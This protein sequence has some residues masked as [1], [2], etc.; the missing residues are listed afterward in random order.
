[1]E[2]IRFEILPPA[3]I[4]H[5]RSMWE[6][7]NEIHRCKSTHFANEY[8][9]FSFEKRKEK[10]FSGGRTEWQVEIARAAPEGEAIAYCLASVNRDLDGEIDSLFVEPDY[11]RFRVADTLMRHALR[12][13]DL[14]GAVSKRIVVAAGNEEVLPF[15][16]FYRF[17]PRHIVLLE[18]KS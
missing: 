13:L 6:K 7:L 15:Y 8:E 4:E 2:D 12:W 9:A 17:Y 11:R 14:H 1:M 10:L 5:I 18:R 3:E 16:E